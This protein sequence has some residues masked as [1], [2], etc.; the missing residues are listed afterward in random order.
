MVKRRRENI[1]NLSHISGQRCPGTRYAPALCLFVLT[2]LLLMLYMLFVAKRETET[3]T[4]RRSEYKAVWPSDD[5]LLGLS[6]RLMTSKNMIR[7]E[8]SKM[9][10]CVWCMSVMKVRRCCSCFYC[11]FLISIAASDSFDHTIMM[12]LISLS[13]KFLFILFSCSTHAPTNTVQTHNNTS[14]LSYSYT[15]QIITIDNE[16]AKVISRATSHERARN[17]AKE[18]AKQ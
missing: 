5:H 1:H 2:V 15:Q 8:I 13:L 10:L 18:Y 9:C 16:R 6:S 12:L 4:E 3:E 14:L 17:K 7:W 11:S